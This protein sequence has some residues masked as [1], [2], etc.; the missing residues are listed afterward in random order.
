MCAVARKN[1]IR[2]GD[3][4]RIDNPIFVLRVGYPKCLDSETDEVLATMGEQLDGLLNLANIEKGGVRF[5]DHGRNCYDQTKRKV[6]RAIAYARLNLHGFG[7]CERTI[8]TVELPELKGLEG[9]VQSVRFAKTGTY[10]PPYY[11]DGGWWGEPDYEPGGLQHEKTHKLLDVALW[12]EELP[13]GWQNKPFEIEA[14]HV[15]K[16]SEDNKPRK[17]QFKLG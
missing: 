12:P 15:T 17:R 10:Y 9:W 14:C 16:V 2:Q 13:A 8:H 1:I 5:T 4:V 7:G 11:S 6:A 3:R